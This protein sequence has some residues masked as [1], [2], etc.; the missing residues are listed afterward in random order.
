MVE[1]N[2]FGVVGCDDG[3]YR[4]SIA[5]AES[6]LSFDVRGASGARVAE[7]AMSLTPL[8]PLLTEY[9]LL[10][11]SYYSAIRSASPRQIEAIERERAA[12]HNQG[13]KLIAERLADKVEID[14]RTARRLFTLVSALNWKK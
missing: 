10:C 12:L 8:R 5:Q 3:P 7:M 9:F 4:M 2:S 6:R 11:E 13:A 1:E 14:E